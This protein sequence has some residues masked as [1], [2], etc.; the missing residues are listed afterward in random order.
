M[1]AYI[2]SRSFMSYL[3]SLPIPGS[4]VPSVF[5]DS[6]FCLFIELTVYLV[7]WM[8]RW[9]W[10]TSGSQGITTG[11]QKNIGFLEI[12]GVFLWATYLKRTNSTYFTTHFKFNLRISPAVHSI[13]PVF[14]THPPPFFFLFLIFQRYSLI[15]LHN[16]RLTTI[17]A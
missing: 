1:S 11:Q 9:I 16:H 15:S 17:S 8:Q 4:S 14:F 13:Q 7:M 6:I 5:S 10:Y 2:H 3:E 12:R